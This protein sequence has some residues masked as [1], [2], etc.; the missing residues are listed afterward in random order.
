MKP[1]V[2]REVPPIMKKHII[3]GTPERWSPDLAMDEEKKSVCIYKMCDMMH[4]Y[5]FHID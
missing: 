3:K 5:F 1:V 2:F 4:S